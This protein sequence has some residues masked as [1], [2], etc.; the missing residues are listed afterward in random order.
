MTILPSTPSR[1]LPPTFQLRY[2]PVSFIQM[3]K[4]LMFIV[5]YS[6]RILLKKDSYK[7]TIMSIMLTISVGVAIAASGEAKYDS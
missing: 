4:A 2:L 6:I 7:S 3:V 1:P 5:V